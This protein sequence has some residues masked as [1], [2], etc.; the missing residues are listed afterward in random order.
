MRIGEVAR[1]DR[2]DLNLAKGI[3][4]IHKSKF[5]KSRHVPLHRSTVDAL[6]G[7]LNYRDL[8]MPKPK[9]SRLFINHLG[10]ALSAWKVRKVFRQLLSEV[11]IQRTFDGRPRIMD[12]RHHLAVD[13]LIRWYKRHVNIDQHIPLLSTYLGHA[14]LRH[15]YWYIT[16]IP[17]LLQ[18]IAS[19]LE[20]NKRGNP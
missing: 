7:Y 20:Y 15:T 3:I 4:T 14:H 10:G 8:Y 19:R 1:L 6:T 13:T 2:N 12:F 16:A 17:E 9:T 18:H 11:G 5:K